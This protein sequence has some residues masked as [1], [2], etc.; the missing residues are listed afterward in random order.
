M[1]A[2]A[3]AG[4]LAPVASN[5]AN[6]AVAPLVAPAVNPTIA[7][8]TQF[9]ITGFMQTATLDTPADPHSGGVLTVNGHTV[10]IPKETI[11]ILP[12][13]ALTWQELFTHAP[14]PYGPTQTGMALADTPKPLTTYEV[15][16]VGNRVISGGQDR[17]IAGLVH[18]AQQDL[19]SGAGHI[20]FIDYTTGELEVGGTSGV[21][22]T[23]TRV[24]INDP[25]VGTTGTGRYG[26]AASPDDRFQVDQDN[27]TIL[28]ETGFPMC[29]PRSAPT[30]TNDDAE[31]P[32]ANRPVYTGTDTSGITP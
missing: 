27:P 19:N 25:A 30:T 3:L 5:A 29:I 32:Q 4:G 6:G 20:N 2:I 23:G 18:I 7:S 28:A 22:G 31:C 10:V 1:A 24:R 13:S 17:Y 12:A 15:H 14:S 11:V 26:R 9:D 16:V 8:S 21:A